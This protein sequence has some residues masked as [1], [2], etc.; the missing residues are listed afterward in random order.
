MPP[1]SKKDPAKPKGV[2]SAYAWFVK[3]RQGSVEVPLPK[4][5]N[6]KAILAERSKVLSV[7]WKDMDDEDKT[8]YY[9]K[10]AIDK[11][12]HDKE[13]TVYK[14]QQVADGEPKKGKKPKDKTKPKKNL[15]AFF[16]FS[17]KVRPTLKKEHPDLKVGPL[18]KLLGQQWGRMDEKDRAPFMR[19]AMKDKERYEFEMDL[20]RKGQFSR[21]GDHVREIEE[22]EEE[23]DDEDEE[24]YSDAED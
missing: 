4:D 5:G 17:N 3:D 19:D 1:K 15:T 22:V 2:V 23:E 7:M 13:M 21:E 14:A 24:D 11:K 20:W 10:A 8:E 12:R 6:K 16:F 9:A 18:A